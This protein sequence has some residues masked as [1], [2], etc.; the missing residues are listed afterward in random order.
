MVGNGVM[1][2]TDDSLNY[3]TTDFYSKHKIFG[4][5]LDELWENDCQTNPNGPRC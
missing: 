1:N 4:N 5:D 2:F 3:A